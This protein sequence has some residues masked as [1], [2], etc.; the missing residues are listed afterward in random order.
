M[1]AGSFSRYFTVTWCRSPR[2]A[3]KIAE[4]FTGVTEV[5]DT[6]LFI[7]AGCS[8]LRSSLHPGFHYI[9]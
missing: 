4:C 1:S 7:I 5:K 9:W 6:I 2:S 8:L 3:Y